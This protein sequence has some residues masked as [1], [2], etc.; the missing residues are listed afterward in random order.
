MSQ[1]LR[2]MK[3]L[4]LFFSFLLIGCDSKAQIIEYLEVEGVC[5]EDHAA[6][7]EGLP[8]VYSGVIT[9]FAY[10]THDAHE[11][12]GFVDRQTPDDNARKLVKSGYQSPNT[13]Y[14]LGLKKEQ[15]ARDTFQAKGI[16]EREA[17]GE[18]PLR[19][20]SCTLKVTKRLDR[21]PSST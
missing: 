10:V 20:T 19:E 15:I 12:Y 8:Y 16:S 7:P 2:N 13:I 17:D 14:L 4:V 21:I 6:Q 1:D 3:T 5:L 9:H 11:I 18:S